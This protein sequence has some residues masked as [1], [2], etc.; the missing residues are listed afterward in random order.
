MRYCTYTVSKP[1]PS[2]PKSSKNVSQKKL[3]LSR[4]FHTVLM[5]TI[6]GGKFKVTTVVINNTC[7]CERTNNAS[8]PPYFT[9]RL[10]IFTLK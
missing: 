5:L 6:K 8:P 4:G 10:L 3:N 9:P 2:L 1:H 7:V